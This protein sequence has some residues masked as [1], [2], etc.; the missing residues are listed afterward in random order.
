MA[1]Q[2]RETVTGRKSPEYT[3]R[4]ANEG[5]KKMNIQDKI[6]EVYAMVQDLQIQPT[7]HNVTRLA[8]I[9]KGMK[10]IFA[11]MM[12]LQEQVTKLTAETKAKDAQGEQPENVAEIP[13]PENDKTEGTADGE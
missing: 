6:N 7:E 10:D 2:V 9:M 8:G 5:G 11:G 12:I 4:Q 13:V 1:E 3:Q